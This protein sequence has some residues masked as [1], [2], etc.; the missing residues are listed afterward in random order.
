MIRIGIT[1]G[2]GSGKSVVSRLMEVMGV[3]V[4]IADTEAKRLM[5]DDRRIRMGLMEIFGKDIYSE[6][7]L[8]RAALAKAMFGCPEKLEAVN[9]LVHP[10]VREDFRRWVSLQN[11]SGY[12]VVAIE[13]A[14][15]VEAGFTS[16]VDTVL[17]VLAPLEVRL[18]R[19]MLRDKAS[20]EAVRKRILSQMDDE[21]KLK[22]AHHV[23]NNDGNN[24]LIPQVAEL[25]A[26]ISDNFRLSL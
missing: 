12:E 17:M 6:G 19:A 26:R 10:L 14:I 25:L 2:I 1:G 24:P 4:Y 8:D 22:H 3:P 20:E 11:A 9:A 15:L 7:I 5:Q 13:S 16:E 23:L 21:D 18:K